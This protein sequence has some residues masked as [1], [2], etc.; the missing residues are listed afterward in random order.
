M[1]Y[2]LVPDRAPAI[3]KNRSLVVK[4]RGETTLRYDRSRHR[5]KPLALVRDA[6]R[7]Y[8]VTKRPPGPEAILHVAWRHA[9]LERAE[10]LGRDG[11]TYRVVYPGKPGG[12]F[13][14]D[15]T[16]AIVERDDGTVFRGDIEITSGSRTGVRTAITTTR[17]I[18]G[19]CCTLWLPNR[20]GVP[21]SRRR[22]HRYPCWPSTGRRR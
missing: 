3:Y 14:P 10:V 12:S 13:G 5:I 20:R 1:A 7:K 2:T 4:W 6:G 8:R 17:A 21:R 9:G 19:S 22:V 11:H 18:T 16:D 15:F